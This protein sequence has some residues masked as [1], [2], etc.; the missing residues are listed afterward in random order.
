[1]DGVSDTAPPPAP[2][3]TA[4]LPEQPPPP[5]RIVD[6]DGVPWQVSGED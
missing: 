1:M 6:V 2:D 3:P 5:G 4:A